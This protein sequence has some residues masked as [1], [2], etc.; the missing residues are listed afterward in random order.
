MQPM[1]PATPANETARI[2]QRAEAGQSRRST[3]RNRKDR[4]GGRQKLF[5]IRFKSSMSDTDVARL[6]REL[7]LVTYLTPKP[8]VSGASPGVVRLDDWSGLFLERGYNHG[9][10]ILE[11]RTW[12][13]PPR[14]AAHDWHLRAALAARALDPTVQIPPPLEHSRHDARARDYA[15]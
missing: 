15:R 11:G 13:D 9:E 5:S 1:T 10:W 12:D 8:G 2:H 14:P 7:D 4:S 3:V 6:Q